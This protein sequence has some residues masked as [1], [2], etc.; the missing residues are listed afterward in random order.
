MAIELRAGPAAR[1]TTLLYSTGSEGGGIALYVAGGVAG[2]AA[3]SVFWESFEANTRPA[4]ATSPAPRTAG[5]PLNGLD[6][7]GAATVS[8]AK[9]AMR[10][11]NKA[12]SE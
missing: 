5:A 1:V 8:E 10:H 3:L 2:V 11:K 12:C 4:A 9:G 6:G 7:A